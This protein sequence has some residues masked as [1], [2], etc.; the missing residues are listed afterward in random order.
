MTIDQIIKVDIAISEAM[1]ID[2]GYDTILI[3]GPLPRTP[4]GHMTP[5]VAGYTGTQDLKSAGFSTDDPVYIAASKVFAQSPKATMVM[6]AV[7]K[8]T[9]GSTEKV[10]ATLDRAKAVPGWY[11]ICP[12]ASRRT[13]IRA[14]QTGQNPTRNSVSARLRAFLHRLFL[15]QCSARPSF[16]QRKKTT[17]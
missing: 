4:G 9:S 1:A 6:V 3:I 17:A 2:G 10:D 11:C 13:S 16:T 5:D 14:S 15:M 12:A 8:T 7:Q